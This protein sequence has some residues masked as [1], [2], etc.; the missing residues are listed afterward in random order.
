MPTMAATPSTSTAPRLARGLHHSNPS[1]PHL[2]ASSSLTPTS[3]S[4]HTVIEDRLAPLPPSANFSKSS[5]RVSSNNYSP[6]APPRQRKAFSI[7]ALPPN[8]FGFKHPSGTASSINLGQFNNSAV[9]LSS[10]APSEPLLAGPST[11]KRTPARM[12]PPPSSYSPPTHS[13]SSRMMRQK[14][15]SMSSSSSSSASASD[16]EV[17]QTP[18]VN[19]LPPGAAMPS[20]PQWP[21]PMPTG[22]SGGLGITVPVAGVDLAS[23]R[24]SP[25]FDEFEDAREF[26]DPEMASTYG[27]AYATPRTFTPQPSSQTQVNELHQQ[28]AISTAPIAP[29]PNGQQMV[30]SLS[31]SSSTDDAGSLAGESMRTVSSNGS[32][33][34]T[35][36]RLEFINSN[37]ESLSNPTTLDELRNLRQVA[38]ELEVEAQRLRRQRGGKPPSPKILPRKAVPVVSVTEYNE[39]QQQQA[40][41]PPVPAARKAARMSLMNPVTVPTF[42]LQVD[43]LVSDEEDSSPLFAPPASRKAFYGLERSAMSVLEFSSRKS[44]PSPEENVPT[45]KPMQTMQAA[46]P[47]HVEERPALGLGLP[48]SPPEKSEA[49]QAKAKALASVPPS[50]TANTTSGFRKFS[51][52]LNKKKSM[53]ISAAAAE[54]EASA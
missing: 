9:D 49:E 38:K 39:L 53:S 17:P 15:P 27:S 51:R 7:Q 36:T 37:F 16:D 33:P 35:P 34:T 50:A 24:S 29:T 31:S 19:F 26:P 22:K 4:T 10:S 13:Y 30:P 32:I 2:N 48:P 21:K 43:P 52:F 44:T 45:F 6:L 11:L 40:T 1:L 5:R 46:A 20:A 42:S 47:L 41:K 18:N 12:A 25:A 54:V 8:A 14:L 28:P 3:S 23:G